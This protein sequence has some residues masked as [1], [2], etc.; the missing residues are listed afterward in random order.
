MMQKKF[1]ISLI[2]CFIFLIV[3]VSSQDFNL[4]NAGDINN[5]LNVSNISNQSSDLV[6]Q[7]GE[8]QTGIFLDGINFVKEKINLR[9]VIYFFVGLFVIYAYIKLFSK[10]E[11]EI[12]PSENLR[13][14]VRGLGRKQAG[15]FVNKKSLSVE[16][17]DSLMK[18]IEIFMENSVNVLSVVEDG[19]IQGMISKPKLLSESQN[20]DPSFLDKKKIKEI[21]EKGFDKFNSGGSLKDICETLLNSKIGSL[22]ILNQADKFIGTVDYFDILSSFS[23]S[24]FVIENPPIIKDAMNEKFSSIDSE[25]SVLDLIKKMIENKKDYA[26]VMK[27]SK[28]IGVV[29]IKDVLSLIYK[30]VYL[31]KTKVQMIMSPRLISLSPG[32][33]IKEAIDIVLEKKFNQLPVIDKDKIYGVL[34][35]DGIVRT[36]YKFLNEI[37]DIRKDLLVRRVDFQT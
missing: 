35:L 12:D 23:K 7:S 22:A 16:T 26:L 36:Y 2:I 33:S 27:D 17:D 29:T 18:A 8:D 28:A 31:D 25:E 5:S 30:G 19:D 6:N 11:E 15:S 4:T 13:G 37:K 14:Y 1:A 3:F 20:K 24:K 32:S 21:M 34:E 10:D 9:H